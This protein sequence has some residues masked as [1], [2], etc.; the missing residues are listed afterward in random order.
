MTGTNNI[1]YVLY[2]IL[3]APRQFP[4]PFCGMQRQQNG[5]LALVCFTKHMKYSYPYETVRN[6]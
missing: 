4:A 3:L 1:I 5:H 2:Y 6:E